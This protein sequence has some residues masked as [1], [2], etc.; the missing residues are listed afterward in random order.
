HDAVLAGAD[1]DVVE[2]ADGDTRELEDLVEVRLALGGDAQ[3]LPVDDDVDRGAVHERHVQGGAA[4]VDG[5]GRRDA[6][7]APGLA[8][9]LDRLAGGLRGGPHGPLLAVDVDADLAGGPDDDEH[10]VVEGGVRVGT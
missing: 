4:T 3:R 5:P 1:D 7:L 2:L 8:E 6:D 10:A 9:G